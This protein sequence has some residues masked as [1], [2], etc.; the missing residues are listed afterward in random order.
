MRFRDHDVHAK[1]QDCGFSCCP[2]VGERSLGETG[3]LN[4]DVRLRVTAIGFQTTE[5]ARTFR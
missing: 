1:P 5:E 2:D 4:A 3:R